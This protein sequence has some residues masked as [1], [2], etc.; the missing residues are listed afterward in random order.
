M[1]RRQLR[2]DLRETICPQTFPCSR[3]T[4]SPS[5]MRH[6]Q[7]L[8]SI[9]RSMVV[10]IREPIWQSNAITGGQ[11]MSEFK[12]KVVVVTGAGGGRALTRSNSQR[13]RESRCQ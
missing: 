12:D 9:A 3:Q 2:D 6:L 7:G 13:G 1:A 11:S 10:V 5:V 4:L 8:D